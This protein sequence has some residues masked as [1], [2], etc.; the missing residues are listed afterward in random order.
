MTQS[1]MKIFMEFNK[2][3]KKTLLGRVFFPVCV[4]FTNCKIKGIFLMGKSL[5]QPSLGLPALLFCCQASHE[6]PVTFHVL[7]G[8]QI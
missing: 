3:S 4:H 2:R 8:R 5:S 6:L 7:S 1:L